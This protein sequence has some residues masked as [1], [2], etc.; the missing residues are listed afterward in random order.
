MS[1]E[2]L[3]RAILEEISNELE[4]VKR[5]L[6]EERLQHKAEIDRI[7]QLVGIFEKEHTAACAP[8]E[9]T[10]TPGEYVPVSRATEAE[11]SEKEKEVLLAGKVD[12]PNPEEKSD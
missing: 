3:V 6:V 11:M 7:R 1:A 9:F 5:Q 4:T 8:Y 12:N 2:I 10:E